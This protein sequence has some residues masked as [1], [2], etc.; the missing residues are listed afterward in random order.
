ME[1]KTKLLV[2]RFILSVPKSWKFCERSH[3]WERGYQ[4]GLERFAYRSDE[5]KFDCRVMKITIRFPTIAV[6]NFALRNLS[7]LQ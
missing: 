3:T 1:K 5:I 4:L 2:M 6:S 7:N